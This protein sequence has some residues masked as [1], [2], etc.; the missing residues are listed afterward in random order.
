METH[1]WFAHSLED[2]GRHLYVSI[3]GNFIILLLS[4]LCC[5]YCSKLVKILLI[6]IYVYM[7]YKIILPLL[8]FSE[9][10]H[11]L[12]IHLWIKV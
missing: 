2:E 1:N 3:C 11:G 7:L 5:L 6:V 9:D 10:C 12:L 4:K 8:I